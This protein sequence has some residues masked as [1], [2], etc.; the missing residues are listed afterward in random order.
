VKHAGRMMYS[1]TSAGFALFVILK[2]ETGA[3]VA[4]DV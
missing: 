1:A 4:F 3:A 2:V